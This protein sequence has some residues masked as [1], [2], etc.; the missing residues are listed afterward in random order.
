LTH[1]PQ[2]IV[3][4]R[5]DI[6]GREV[7][8]F[9][10]DCLPPSWFDKSPGKSYRQQIDDMLSATRIADEICRDEMSSDVEFFPAWM[11]C[12]ER[13]Q[14]N[15]RERGFTPLLTSFG[16]SLVERAVIDALCRAAQLP[17][18][19]ALRENIFHIAGGRVHS[20]LDGHEPAAWLPP[21]PQRTMYVRHTVGLSDPIVNGDL[22]Q[23]DR[24]GD[25]FPETLQDYIDATGVRYFKIKVSN[26]L[27]ADLPRLQKIAALIESRR[28]CDYSI[29]LDGN[30]QYKCAEQFDELV[31]AIER[32]PEL[33]QLWKNTLVVEQPLERAIA[34][35]AEHTAGIR[36]LGRR[37]P[38]IIDESDGQLESFSQALELGYRGVSSKN[39]KGPIKSVLN[40]GLIWSRNRSL[41]ARERLVMTGEDLCSVGVVSMQSDLCL[42]A[43]LGLTH[44]E[45]NGHHYHAGLSYLPSSQVTAALAEH[46]DLYADQHNRP[47]PLLCDGALAT[48]TTV[49]AVGFGFAVRPD[50]DEYSS[51]DQ[52]SYDS[53]GIE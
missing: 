38:V 45:R 43:T 18:A 53:L 47:A 24:I 52:W 32:R 14:A 5:V 29:T 1:C 37:K 41:D 7:V 2:A 44:V 3:S 6:G 27:D 13:L 23:Q 30:E 10:G 31:D 49:D 28:G 17:L 36:E 48:G 9:S 8:G 21:S 50:L 12:Y 22:D 4:A 35:L 42:V 11:A 39:C 26:Q 46:G 19:K 34:L 51:I 33:Q 40:A 20:E 16:L 25:G 15:G